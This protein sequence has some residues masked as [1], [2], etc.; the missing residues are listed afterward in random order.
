MAKKSSGGRGRVRIL[1]ADV[2]GDDETILSSI[3]ALHSVVSKAS[4]PRVV[5]QIASPGPQQA[6]LPFPEDEE[7][8]NEADEAVDGNVV[9]GMVEPERKKVKRKPPQMSIVKELDLRPE[10]HFSLRDFYAGLNP[11]TQTKQVAV[12]IYYLKHKAAV[13]KV[14]ANHVFT[15]YKEV[16]GKSPGDLPQIIRN[17]AS[18][19][20]WV[21]C[22]DAEDIKITNRGE[23]LVEHDL[24]PAGSG[25][26]R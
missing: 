23:A 7:L 18:K 1:Y 22:T 5:R 19:H 11:E 2:E 20:G 25:T 16:S 6:A 14:S 9:D 24:V 17:T 13:E 26:P 21:D 3:N 8:D 10:G 4:Q 15:C 12:F